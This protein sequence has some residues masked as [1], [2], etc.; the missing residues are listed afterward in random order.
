MVISHIC[1]ENMEPQHHTIAR[2]LWTSAKHFNFLSNNIQVMNNAAYP[3]HSYD[4]NDNLDENHMIG[5]L[6][7]HF[8]AAFIP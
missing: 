6:Q 7:A 1:H 8:P 3:A 4:V 2:G 5:Q